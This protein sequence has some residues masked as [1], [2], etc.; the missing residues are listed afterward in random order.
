MRRLKPTI[1]IS[2]DAWAAGFCERVQV[3]LERDLGYQGSLVQSYGLVLNGDG[4][5]SLESDLA[6][7][8]NRDF[9]LSTTRDL[10]RSTADDIQ[11]S[12]EAKSFDLEPKLSEILE[13]GLR[14]A[15]IER[16]RLLGLDVARNR[17]VHLLLSSVDSAGNGVFIELARLIRWL[18]GA[19]FI[20][21]LY[22]LHAVVLLPNLFEQPSQ[23]D[24]A[25]AYG[26]VKKLDYNFASGLTITPS[27]KMPPFDGCWFID[28]INARGEKIGTLSD[29]LDSYTDAFTGF[30]TAE[31]EMSGALVGTRTCRGKIPAYSTFGHGE[32]YLPV[33]VAVI[34]L[35]SALSRD[36]LDHAFISEKREQPEIDRKMLLAAKQF[37]LSD[38]YRSAVDG[39]ETENGALIWQDPKRPAE[40]QRDSD[41]LQYVEEQRRQHAK[42]ERESLPKFKQTLLARS[43]KS[44]RELVKLLDA[45]IDRRIDQAPEGLAEGPS[46]LQRLVDHSIALHSNALGERPQNLLTDLLA[47]ESALDQGLGLTIDHSRTEALAKQVDELN[48]RLADL[49]HTLRL[50]VSRAHDAGDATTETLDS[51]HD[52]LQSEIE[53]TRSEIASASALYVREL[54]A[55]QRAANELRYEAKENLRSDRLAAITAA[56]EELTQTAALLSAA[57]LELEAREQQRRSFLVRHFIIY[58]AV[59]ALL[60]IAPGLASFLGISFAT[61]LVGL[62]W[63]SLFG[64]LLGTTFMLAVYTAAVL[65]LFL[66]GINKVVIAARDEV[67][68]LELRLKAAQVRLTDAHNIQLRLEHDIYAQSLRVETLNRLIEVTRERISELE[69]VLGE[70]REC[71]ATFVSRYAMAL[72]ASSYMRRSV[73]NGE[74]IDRYYTATIRKI[75]IDAGIFIREH[76]PRSQ[77]RHLPMENFAQRLE[78]FARSRFQ[79][80]AKLSIK[81]VLLGSP[82]LFSEAQASLRLEEL[83]RA[84]S[85]LA[86]L[87]EMDL[88]DDTFAQKDVTIWAGATDNESLLDR[89]RKLNTTTTIRPSNDEHSLRALTRCLNFPAFYLSQIEFYRSCYDRLHHKDASSLPDI[90]PDELTISA[91]SRHAYEHL[92]VSIAVGLIARNRDG[93]YQLVDDNGSLTGASRRE[94]AEQLAR[95]YRSQKT[96]SKICNRLA[97]CDSGRIYESVIDFLGTASDLDPFERE[98]LMA[99]SQKYHPLR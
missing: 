15:E 9:N 89:Y 65:Y 46:L 20:Q 71:R 75:D 27:R 22:E 87:S 1:L 10:K 62:F 11:S 12:F 96:Y 58:P 37:V 81:D 69:N 7:I 90:I 68:A 59:A 49:E 6:A 16:A 28:G 63:A 66:K 43:E 21:E 67:H 72:P 55:E 57:R 18:F 92:L 19:R 78:E 14:A 32:L 34:R 99:V 82:E 53:E 73:L 39:I 36:I 76:V 29:E 17:M 70:L 40:L 77:V 52:S 54:I 3:K 25:A 94:I 41:A 97:K 33:E 8:A 84:S 26:L 83:D 38:N 79:S 86:M 91:D 4:P 45:E 98:M 61:M 23:A 56:E 95:D 85:P 24:F 74:Q 35:S 5:P 31:P 88:N 80:F 44:R 50:T 93:Q 47:A 60:F 13:A 42:F 30:L 51:E 2:L 64:F 48:N